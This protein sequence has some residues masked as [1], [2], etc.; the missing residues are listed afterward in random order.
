[1]ASAFFLSKLSHSCGSSGKRSI[2]IGVT[3]VR[4]VFQRSTKSGCDRRANCASLTTT[5]QE[6]RRSNL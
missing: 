1:M 3:A 6:D 2:Q 4:A 5:R